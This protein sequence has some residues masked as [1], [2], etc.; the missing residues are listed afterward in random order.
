VIALGAL[1]VVLAFMLAELARSRRNE[2]LLF[3]RGAVAVPDPAYGTMRWAYPAAFVAMAVEGAVSGPP[4]I[5]FTVAGGA[6]FAAAKALKFWAIGSLGERWTYRVF[7]LPGEPLV[8]RGPYRYMRHPNYVGV[9]GELVGM[10]LLTGARI[11]GPIGLV[12]FGWLLLR[13]IQAEEKA[14]Y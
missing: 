9:V 12:C 13:R 10:A 6:V 5:A 3:A 4:P 2:R 8:T 14:I 11:T 1:A 7:V